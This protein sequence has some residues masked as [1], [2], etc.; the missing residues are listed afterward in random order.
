MSY[1]TL[2]PILPTLQDIITNQDT[3]KNFYLI[4]GKCLEIVKVDSSDNWKNIKIEYGKDDNIYRSIYRKLFRDYITPSYPLLKFDIRCIDFSSDTN[5][6]KDWSS[7]LPITI[8]LYYKN[9]DD[10]DWHYRTSYITTIS[11]NVKAIILIGETKMEI[12]WEI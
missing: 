9:K 7:N 5:E 11:G 4:L 10:R 2:P 8:T 12:T 6:Y 3:W 1:S